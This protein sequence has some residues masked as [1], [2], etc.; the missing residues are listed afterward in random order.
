MLPHSSSSLCL[1]ETPAV[2]VAPR[3]A[4]RAYLALVA[5][6]GGLTTAVMLMM[7]VAANSGGEAD[8]IT[9]TQDDSY[10]ATLVAALAVNLSK[11]QR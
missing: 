11:P 7:S 9:A 4:V 2:V 10:A 3:A 5:A 8:R 1:G 6:L